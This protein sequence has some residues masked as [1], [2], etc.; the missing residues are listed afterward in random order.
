[1]GLPIKINLPEGFL[2]KEVRYGYEVS[3]KLKKIWAIELDLLNEFMRVCAKHDIKYTIFGGTLLGAIR[4]HG[5]I[6]WDDDLDVALTREEY[7]KLCRVAEAEF[8]HPY[9]FQTALS[10]RRYFCAYAR[11]RNS[12]T[13]AAIRGM[14]TKD[15]NNG[16]YIDVYV[17]EGYYDSKFMWNFQNLLFWF[18]VKPLNLYY[19]YHPL[20]NLLK[21]R[22]LR[23]SR[24][25]FRM[26][27]YR[28]WVS[29]YV[30]VQQLAT[31]GSSRIGLRDEISETAKRYWLYK[32][33]LTDL[34]EV[35]FEMLKVMMVRNY[36]EVL[37]RIYGDYMQFPPMEERGQWHE[38]LIH[39]EPDV[40]Y[41]DYLK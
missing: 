33:E 16:I 21:E 31:K 36:D 10:D 22:V 15:Y 17:L 25:F 1:M 39:F 34:V 9:F 24:P 38:G 41:V 35:D 28:L 3:G 18:A 12:E 40:P 26:F 6:P 11:L 14:A 20:T 32:D 2:D 29:I 23:M 7:N 13:T 19:K 37:R 8:N 4:H 5:F 30:K 27:P